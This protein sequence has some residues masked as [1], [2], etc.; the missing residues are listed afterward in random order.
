VSNHFRRWPLL[1]LALTSLLEASTARAE[2]PPAASA[3]VTC[4]SA[5]GQRVECPA[6]T[7][8]GVLLR[9]ST[10]IA[11]CLL[12]KNWGYSDQSIWVSDGCAGDFLAAQ[13]SQPPAPEKTPSPE[14]ILNRGFRLYEGQYGQMYLRLFTY[15]RYLNQLALASSYTDYFGN[16]FTVERRQDVQMTKV[17]LPFSGWFLSPKFTYYLYTWSANTAQGQPAQVV[18][19]GNI[20]YQFL[21]WM[22]LGLGI[23]ALPTTRSTEGQFPFWLGVDDRLTADEFFRGSY[24]QGLWL[25]GE[26]VPGLN[27]MAMLANNLSALG[28]SA[29]QLDNL[30]NTW[31]LMMNWL[32][33]TGEFGKFGSFGDYDWHDRVATRLGAHYTQS[34]ETK[35]SQPE[36]NSIE[37]TQIRLTDGS[38]VFNPSLFGPGISVDR[39]T[40]QM[41]AFDTG[42]K[43]KGLSLDGEYFLRRLSNFAGTQT[44]GLAPIV[45]QGFQVQS[46]AMVMP[47]T[48]QVYLSGSGIF[49]HYGDAWEIRSGISWWFLKTRGVRWNTEWIYLYHCP[50]G[51]TAVPYPVGGTGNVFTSTVELSF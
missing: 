13:L 33:T 16:T 51:Y 4:T 7:S 50:V 3:T 34:R 46:S 5:A 25:K 36:T 43:Y 8:S 23:G 18:G 41:W 14:Y 32:P 38:V 6:D 30:V 20:N 11:S 10:G 12:G 21:R 17:F 44:S 31:T 9:N 27:Y 24:T 29:A 15:V 1:A 22:T 48:V 2:G 49:G 47:Q 42:I 40:Y 37:N 39:V 45:D 19:A 26:L 28:V 35:E